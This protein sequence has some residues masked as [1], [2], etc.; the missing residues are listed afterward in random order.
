M[1]RGRGLDG[2][3]VEETGEEDEMNLPLLPLGG[4]RNPLYGALWG[5]GT[6]DL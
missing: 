6:M 4:E 5:E 1:G 2:G 3:V